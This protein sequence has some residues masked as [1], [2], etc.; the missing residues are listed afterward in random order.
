MAHAKYLSNKRSSLLNIRT[1][2]PFPT[3]I[4]LSDE[5]PQRQSIGGVFGNGTTVSTF[6]SALDSRTLHSALSIRSC[7]SE[8]RS[9]IA[10][11]V[12]T[13]NSMF[14]SMPQSTWVEEHTDGISKGTSVVSDVQDSEVSVA[15]F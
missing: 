7:K 13:E 15:V 9:G 4:T 12:T 6:L 14:Y 5:V 11:L 10:E 2:H 8:E 1:T 3:I